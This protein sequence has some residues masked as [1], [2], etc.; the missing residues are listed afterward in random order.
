MTP[1]GKGTR[2]GKNWERVILPV[3]EIHYPGRFQTQVP[4]GVQIY[5]GTYYADLVIEDPNGNVIVSAKWQQVPG[6]AEQKIIYDIASLIN[7]MKRS[8]GR[9]RKCYV[10][11]GGPGFSNGARSFLLG[12]GHRQI[13][14]NADLVEV[15]S[16]DGFLARANQ[17]TL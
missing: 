1:G 14:A 16:L 17:G 8:P 2:S 6:T 11:L 7:I 12:Q 10:V 4:I 15:I 13:F 5:G 3:L 9:C